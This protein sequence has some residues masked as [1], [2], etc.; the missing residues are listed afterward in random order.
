MSPLLLNDLNIEAVVSSFR[1]ALTKYAME[2]DSDLAIATKGRIDIVNRITIIRNV[3]GHDGSV[4]QE[5]EYQPLL[6]KHTSRTPLEDVRQL[7]LLA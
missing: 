7:G 1:E 2:I 4:I 6:R 5:F 3:S